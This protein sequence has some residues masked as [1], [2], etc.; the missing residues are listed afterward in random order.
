MPWPLFSLFSLGWMVLEVGVRWVFTGCPLDVCWVSAAVRW[1][2]AGCPL[3]VCWV[4]AGCLLAILW[5]RG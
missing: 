1:V 5:V 4:F 2:S 3:G